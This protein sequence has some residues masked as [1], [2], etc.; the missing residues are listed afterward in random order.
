MSDDRY[1]DVSNSVEHRNAS[2]N[3]HF[4]YSIS[5]EMMEKA[6]ERARKMD[7]ENAPLEEDQ[8]DDSGQHLR[9]NTRTFR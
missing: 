8:I 2:G 6:K 1:A 5:P 4:T 7:R 9:R 3:V